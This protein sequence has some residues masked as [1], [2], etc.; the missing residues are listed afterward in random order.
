M[1]SAIEIKKRKKRKPKYP[2][3]T[4]RVNAVRA[5]KVRCNKKKKPKA[6]IKP[7]YGNFNDRYRSGLFKYLIL[8]NF[9]AMVTLTHKSRTTLK[10]HEVLI[11]RKLKLMV[12]KGFISCFFKV[13]EYKDNKYHCHILVEDAAVAK[14]LAGVFKR[15][16]KEN[17]NC[18]YKRIKSE[19]DKGKAV[20]YCLKQLQPES[21]KHSI[22]ELID[23]WDYYQIPEPVV[24]VDLFRNPDFLAYIRRSK[25]YEYKRPA[26]S[27]IIPGMTLNEAFN[28]IQAKMDKRITP[29]NKL[30]AIY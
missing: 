18:D 8:K 4:E 28:R 26:G 7:L 21:R 1:M 15:W 10:Q 17:G 13:N 30:V 19:L 29:Q 2:T 14:D 22:Q 6:M 20:N 3:E 27:L 9:H 24:Q 12:G 25:D 5:S 23:T 11:N 16:W